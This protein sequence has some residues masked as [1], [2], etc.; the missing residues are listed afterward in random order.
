MAIPLSQDKREAIVFHKLKGE[1]ETDIAYWLCISQSSVTKIWSLYNKQNTVEPMPHNKGRKP[2]FEQDVLDKI[3]TRI[4]EKNDITLLELIEEFDLK[5]SVSALSRKLNKIDLNFKKRLYFQKNNN[6]K[7][8][9]NSV[10][11]GSSISII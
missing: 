5:I 1:K 2:A 9:K 7:M 6:G 8:F 10:K 4:K 11:S 3:V